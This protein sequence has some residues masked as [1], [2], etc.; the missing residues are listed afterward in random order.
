MLFNADALNSI[1][2]SWLNMFP[3]SWW[4]CVLT[5]PK[6]ECK[7]IRIEI[8]NETSAMLVTRIHVKTTQR[9]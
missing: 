6:P 8:Y 9:V 7:H 2:L 4:L 5:Q 3:R 1:L